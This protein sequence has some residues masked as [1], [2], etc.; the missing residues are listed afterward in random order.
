MMLGRV[1]I[2]LILVLVVVWSVGGMLRDSRG[3]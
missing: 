3:R 1:L 2:L